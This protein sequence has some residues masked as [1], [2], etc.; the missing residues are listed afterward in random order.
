M[1]Y[2][3]FMANLQCLG[4]A[5][6]DVMRSGVNNFIGCR[7]PRQGVSTSEKLS[8]CHSSDYAY[9]KGSV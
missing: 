4:K 1:R 7:G 8:A 5:D 2:N 6:V 3:G 9:Q